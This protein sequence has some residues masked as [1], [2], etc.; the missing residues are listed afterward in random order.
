[1]IDIN[2]GI[3]GKGLLLIIVMDHIDINVKSALCGSLLGDM[4]DRVQA[5]LILIQDYN[6]NI[7]NTSLDLY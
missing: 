5:L 2:K 7:A 3:T 1:M 4:C 6:P